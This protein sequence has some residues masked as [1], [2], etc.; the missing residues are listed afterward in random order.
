MELDDENGLGYECVKAANGMMKA[1][2]DTQSHSLYH[3][4]YLGRAECW[5]GSE[6]MSLVMRGFSSKPWGFIVSKSDET[7]S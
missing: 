1:A 7:M 4:E 3:F 5:K 6:E 2:Q